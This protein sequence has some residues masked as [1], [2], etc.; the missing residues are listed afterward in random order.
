[1]LFNSINTVVILL[2]LFTGSTLHYN[3]HSIHKTKVLLNSYQDLVHITNPGTVVVNK[4][5]LKLRSRIPGHEHP[6]RGCTIFL[7]LRKM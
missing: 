7:L 1:M 4:T 3:L 5:D 2:F 6:G